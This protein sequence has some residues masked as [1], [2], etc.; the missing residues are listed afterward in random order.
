MLATMVM[1]SLLQGSVYAET[2]NE[3]I[4]EGTHSFNGNTNL[5]GG[6]AV[7]QYE[8]LQITV[9]DG[10]LSFNNNGWDLNFGNYASAK[11]NANNVFFN[12]SKGIR[13][14][15]GTELT[16]NAEK[17]TFKDSNIGIDRSGSGQNLHFTG[18]V[19][20]TGNLLIN[21]GM[22]VLMVNTM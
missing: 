9:T 15:T 6:A 1:L 16:I 11:I 8:D 12:G 2:I 4:T 19:I 13:L 10:D 22:D 17:I 14:G 5:N 18:N 21:H 20:F 7:S 3:T